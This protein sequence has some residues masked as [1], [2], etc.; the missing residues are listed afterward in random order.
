MHV[1]SSDHLVLHH[2]LNYKPFYFMIVT[3]NSLAILIPSLC[4]ALDK[5]SLIFYIV[6]THG[7]RHVTQ[8]NAQCSFDNV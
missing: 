3:I 5:A 1:L 2:F 4:N 6:T 8:I 7:S